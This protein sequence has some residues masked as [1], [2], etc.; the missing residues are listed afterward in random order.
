[1]F[2]RSTALEPGTVSTGS[3]LRFRALGPADAG[4]YAARV[5]TDSARSFR[6][7]LSETTTCYAV[8]SDDGIVHAS[9]VTTQC[10]W[11][12]EVRA[13]FCVAG[14][15]AYVYESFTHPAA[16]GR[17]VYPFALRR[18]CE[19]LASRGIDALWVAVESSNQ[20]SLRAV[21][22]A[23]FEESFRLSYR[24]RLGRLRIELPH[25]VKTDTTATRV[26]KKTRIWL[27]GDGVSKQWK[28]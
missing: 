16:R 18:I 3:E 17:G 5:G 7:R 6:E 21:A 10:A 27:T 25:G 23:G 19:D 22:K 26:F 4:E 13:Y 24:R 20:P 8:E 11:T 14:A 15:N 12:R 9:W 28:P 2:S 1:M